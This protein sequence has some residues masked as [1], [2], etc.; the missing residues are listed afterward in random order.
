MMRELLEAWIELARQGVFGSLFADGACE[1]DCDCIVCETEGFL[2]ATK[3]DSKAQ[4]R[5]ERK[6]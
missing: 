5:R 1:N 6:Q 4:P 3:K 2:K